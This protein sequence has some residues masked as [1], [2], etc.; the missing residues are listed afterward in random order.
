[1]KEKK[2]KE[3][4]TS[5]PSEILPSPHRSPV[6]SIFSKISSVELRLM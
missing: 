6:V 3:E 2:E 4:K 5:P 1:M